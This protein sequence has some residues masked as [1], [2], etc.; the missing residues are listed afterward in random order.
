[1]VFT[2]KAKVGSQGMDR[3]AGACQRGDVHWYEAVQ[4][5]DRY[6]QAAAQRAVNEAIDQLASADA[7]SW[8]KLRI[9][10]TLDEK[11]AA[12]RAPVSN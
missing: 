5:V 4:W 3:L 2:V 10:I 1:M 7:R 11:G 12:P 9:A 8:E 6:V